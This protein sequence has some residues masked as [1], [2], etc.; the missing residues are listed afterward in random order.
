MVVGENLK[1]R[2]LF[3]VIL[4]FGFFLGKPW[5]EAMKE[6]PDD[7]RYATV[8]FQEANK[9]IAAATPGKKLKESKK[10]LVLPATETE[11]A[12]VTAPAAADGMPQPE[13][14][15]S[16]VKVKSE[17]TNVTEETPKHKK[18]VE[19]FNRLAD[20]KVA[21]E[22][23]PVF[24]GTNEQGLEQYEVTSENGDHLMQWKKGSELLVESITLANGDNVVRRYPNS[25]DMHKD[26][27]PEIT[28]TSKDG[29]SAS[30]VYYDHAGNPVSSY[31]RVGN[32]LTQYEYDNQGRVVREENSSRLN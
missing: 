32:N 27:T 17:K 1:A 20:L 19:V 14:V 28:Y 15:E 22:K 23:D 18:N 4:I 10:N 3:G 25:V 7:S 21:P 8:H 6:N 29:K 31:V 24:V 2:I 16:E 12:S 11:S 5:L 13:I 9:V 30:G 26:T